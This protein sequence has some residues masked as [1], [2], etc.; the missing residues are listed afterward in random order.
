MP[1]QSETECILLLRLLTYTILSELVLLLELDVDA[2]PP[3]C[4]PLLDAIVMPLDWLWLE[5]VDD[6]L[7]LV[8][9]VLPLVEFV[10]EGERQVLEA[11]RYTFVR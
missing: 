1:E 2:L 6:G 7:E 3:V 9:W 11:G 10:L 4:S 8:D 5:V